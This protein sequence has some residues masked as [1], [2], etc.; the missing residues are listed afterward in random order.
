M[1][2]VMAAK[3]RFRMLA[4]GVVLSSVFFD[5]LYISAGAIFG[6][7]MKKPEDI[8]VEFNPIYTVLVTVGVLAVIYLITFTVRYFIKRRKASQ[9]VSDLPPQPPQD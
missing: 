8:G 2:L 5:G 9:T 6:K 4:L 7:L 3:K 1:L